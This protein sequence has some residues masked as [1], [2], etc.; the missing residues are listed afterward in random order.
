MCVYIHIYMYTSS[1]R[2]EGTIDACLYTYTYIHTFLISMRSASFWRRVCLR[3]SSICIKIHVC[4]CICKSIYVYVFM[5]IH[6]CIY[7]HIHTYIYTYTH[8]YIHK[9]KD[10]CA[11]CIHACI[12]SS[13][14][15]KHRK[16]TC[17]Y[18]RILCYSIYPNNTNLQTHYTILCV[19]L[20]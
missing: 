11:T 3:C 16:N 17:M 14:M 4:M 20:Q 15:H 7:I 1:C 18:E 10:T 5:Y 12:H 2:H 8:T 19:R 13:N 6:I 9:Y